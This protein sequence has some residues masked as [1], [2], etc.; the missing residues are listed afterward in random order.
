MSVSADRTWPDDHL[1]PDCRDGKHGACRGDA[2]C[3][4]V[5]GEHPCDCSCHVE[6]AAS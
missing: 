3:L 1:S 2:W 4:L 6:A 5:D